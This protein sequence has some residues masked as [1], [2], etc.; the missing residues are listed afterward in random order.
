MLR[1]EDGGD[2]LDGDAV[3]EDADDVLMSAHACAA[4]LGLFP[5]AAAGS[6]D[7]IQLPT[8]WQISS[9]PEPRHDQRV[10]L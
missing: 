1:A 10:G 3:D 9:R 6:R 2:G 8:G 7:Q 5:C 4:L